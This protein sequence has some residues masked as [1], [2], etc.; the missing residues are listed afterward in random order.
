MIS[1]KSFEGHEP[2]SVLPLLHCGPRHCPILPAQVSDLAS[3]GLGSIARGFAST[4][5]RVKMTSGLLKKISTG[6]GKPIY[7]FFPGGWIGV[8]TYLC[9]VTIG[10][11]RAQMN[12]V[13]CTYESASSRQ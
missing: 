5:I 9:A 8:T 13:L 6:T 2:G 10:R 12:V 3:R 7:G 1:F 11:H 4:N